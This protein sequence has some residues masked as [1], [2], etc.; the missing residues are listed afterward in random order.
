MA[1]WQRIG[2]LRVCHW[3]N[4][5]CSKK[6]H[7]RLPKRHISTNQVKNLQKDFVNAIRTIYFIQIARKTDFVTQ[8]DIFVQLTSHKSVPNSNQAPSKTHMSELKD[9]IRL[10]WWKYIFGQQVLTKCQQKFCGVKLQ[11]QGF[12]MACRP[13]LCDVYIRFC[14]YLNFQLF[15]INFYN[16]FDYCKIQKI[17]K[18]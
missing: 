10:F 4:A 5:T 15:S 18:I 14:K 16:F 1:F 17:W 8:N 7:W 12:Q 9:Q 6:R 13:M 2:V 11:Y 3:K